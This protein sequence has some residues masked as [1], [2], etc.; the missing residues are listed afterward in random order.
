[1]GRHTPVAASAARRKVLGEGERVEEG[2]IKRMAAVTT[3]CHGG[4]ERT[5]SG[6]PLPPGGRRRH[7]PQQRRHRRGGD[8]GSGCTEAV[9]TNEGQ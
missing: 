6:A 5:A 9:K 7:P 1:M 4:D 2:E 8:S 3:W